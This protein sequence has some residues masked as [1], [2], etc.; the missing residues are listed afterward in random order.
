ML[1]QL[2][3][4]AWYSPFP[5]YQSTERPDKA[6][7]ALLEGRIVILVDNSPMALI[8]PV[9]LNSF[10]QASDDYYS[11]WEV[12]SFIRILRYLAAIIAIGAPGLYIAITN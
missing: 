6:A 2:I 11:R 3:E 10:F 12:V 1:E 8:L 7:S 5:Q 9:T 4:H